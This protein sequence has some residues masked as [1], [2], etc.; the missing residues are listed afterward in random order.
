MRKWFSQG[1][2]WGYDL[3][4]IDSHCKNIFSLFYTWHNHDRQNAAHLNA[5]CEE[6]KVYILQMLCIWCYDLLWPPVDCLLYFLLMYQTHCRQFETVNSWPNPGKLQAFLVNG[7]QAFVFYSLHPTF[8]LKP[9]GFMRSHILPWVT[10]ELQITPWN[11]W[12]K[13]RRQS[14]ITNPKESSIL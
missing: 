14:R 7:V 3:K 11:Q 10:D 6:L 13:W 2:F 12:L 9:P 4:Y 5:S 8:I 1:V